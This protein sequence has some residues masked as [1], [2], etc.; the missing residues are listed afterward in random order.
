[1]SVE[2]TL[3]YSESPNRAKISWKNGF[4]TDR[5]AEQPS[6]DRVFEFVP[7]LQASLTNHFCVNTILNTKSDSQPF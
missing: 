6:V 2:N 1:M 3:G 4:Q 7:W 5:M